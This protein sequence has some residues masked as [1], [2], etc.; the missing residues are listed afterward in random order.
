MENARIDAALRRMYRG[1]RRDMDVM[2]ELLKRRRPNI[3]DIPMNQ[4]P[5]ELLFQIT[6]C[7]GA[8][9]DARRFYGQ[10]VSEIEAV[11]SEYLTNPISTV[12]DSLMAT[13]RVYTLFLNV[14]PA[15]IRRAHV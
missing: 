13:S 14:S 4:V 8:S 3:F 12:A 7:G 5:S 6:L 9:D 10:V 2:R 15:E 11:V 1:L